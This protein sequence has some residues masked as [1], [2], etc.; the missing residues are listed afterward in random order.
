MVSGAHQFNTT[1]EVRR[2]KK[3]SKLAYLYFFHIWNNL[4]CNFYY[5]PASNSANFLTENLGENK[6]YRQQFLWDLKWQSPRPIGRAPD[7]QLT[8]LF[9]PSFLKLAGAQSSLS[10]AIHWILSS[11]GS[12]H[13]RYRFQALTVC[14][15]P[16]LHLIHAEHDVCHHWWLGSI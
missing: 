4:Q 6:L 1:P 13:C 12:F 11:E 2:Y 5:Y 3:I 15:L 14:L 9:P 8:L 16:G 10:W 7:L